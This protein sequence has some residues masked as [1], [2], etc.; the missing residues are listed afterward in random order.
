MTHHIISRGR[1]AV[2]HNRFHGTRAALATTRI[3]GITPSPT[4]PIAPVFVREHDDKNGEQNVS[5]GGC[6]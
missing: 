1:I 4:G 5:V 6:S 3:D 2:V